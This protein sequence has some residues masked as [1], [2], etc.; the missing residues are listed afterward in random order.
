MRLRV[1]LLKIEMAMIQKQRVDYF[2][3]TL[4]WV[5]FCLGM[6]ATNAKVSELAS[7]SVYPP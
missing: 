5:N 3:A 7:S 6:W 1:S 4:F 2:S